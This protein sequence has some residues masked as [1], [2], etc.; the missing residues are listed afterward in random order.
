M[1]PYWCTSDTYQ[2]QT[3]YAWQILQVLRFCLF[4]SPLC[5]GCWVFWYVMVQ[6]LPSLVIFIHLCF[7]L[8]HAQLSETAKKRD[9]SLMSYFYRQLWTNNV[10]F[11]PTTWKKT[12]ND[13]TNTLTSSTAQFVIDFCYINEPLHSFIQCDIKCCYTMTGG[14]KR[15]KAHYYGQWNH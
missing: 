2:C 14:N 11:R 4:V 6:H 13:V 9:V 5:W 3:R 10:K 1:S 12:C 8:T 7:L 15:L